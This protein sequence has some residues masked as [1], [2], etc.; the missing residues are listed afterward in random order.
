MVNFNKIFLE[1][2]WRYRYNI[3]GA[4]VPNWWYSF[5]LFQELLETIIIFFKYSNNRIVMAKL[6]FTTKCLSG[7]W[8]Y[9]WTV[10]LFHWIFTN[11]IN[12]IFNN[13]NTY[14]LL[15]GSTQSEYYILLLPNGYNG[16][17]CS[18]CF[19]HSHPRQCTKRS[20]LYNMKVTI[21]IWITRDEW[22]KIQPCAK[23][24]ARAESLKYDICNNGRL[25]YSTPECE[26]SYLNCKSGS[27]G[28]KSLKM[29]MSVTGSLWLKML[30]NMMN[31][32]FMNKNVK[33]S[34]VRYYIF[35]ATITRTFSNGFSWIFF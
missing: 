25:L 17:K 33:C 2:N 18:D 11:S 13:C 27:Y 32:H 1:Y 7:I 16:E 35:D 15:Q 19:T 28:R 31:F 12:T 22:K 30:C 4:V 10:S 21:V 34:Y 20:L 24:A 8:N 26:D 6:K 23:F 14:I 29:Y 9:K 3:N 5:M